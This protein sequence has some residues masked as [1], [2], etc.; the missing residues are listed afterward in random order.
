MQVRA[1]FNYLR[2]AIVL[3]ALAAPVSAVADSAEGVWKTEP[4]GKGGY[5]HIQIAPCQGEGGRLCGRITRIIS[6][7]RNDLV[8][9]ELIRDMVAEGSDRWGDGNIYSPD[10]NQYYASQMIL[11]GDELEV[12]GCIAALCKSQRWARVE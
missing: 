5:A 11:E 7:D 6:S 8:G 10:K 9:V 12:R 3:F 2:S 1:A 4:M